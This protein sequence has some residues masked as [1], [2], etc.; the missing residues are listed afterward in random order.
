MFDTVLSSGAVTSIYNGGTPTDLSSQVDLLGYWRN[1]DTAGTSVYPT[2]KDDSSNSN[3]GTMINMVAGDI[4]T[5]A[6]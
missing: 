2:I 5:D 6:P 4:I 1:G 3:D